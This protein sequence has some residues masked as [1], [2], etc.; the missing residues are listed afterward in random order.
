MIMRATTFIAVSP[1]AAA[2]YDAICRAAYADAAAR[3]T[4]LCRL[5][6]DYAT[7]CASVY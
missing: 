2:D 3:Y 6:H 1:P 7:L 4:S 5:R